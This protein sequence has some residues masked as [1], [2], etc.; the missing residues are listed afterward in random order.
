MIK[1]KQILHLIPYTEDY[2]IILKESENILICVYDT[3]ISNAEDL[4][5]YKNYNV[6]QIDI[7]CNAIRIFIEEIK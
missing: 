4:M 7:H 6:Y 1:L 5:E 2:E 3:F